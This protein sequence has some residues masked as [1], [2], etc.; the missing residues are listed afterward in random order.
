M[1]LSAEATNYKWWQDGAESVS[2]EG[3]ENAAYPV[4]VPLYRGKKADGLPHVLVEIPTEAG[5]P[6][7]SLFGLALTVG[8]NSISEGQAKG[9]GWKIKKSTKKTKKKINFLKI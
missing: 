4:E 1:P 5:E 6:K 8:A 3:S 9:F 7:K 2:L